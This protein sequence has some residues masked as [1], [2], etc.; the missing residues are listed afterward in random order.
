MDN[1]TR[2]DTA[3]LVVRT[4]AGIGG[5]VTAL[6]VTGCTSSSGPPVGSPVPSGGSAS[7]A[8]GSSAA[9][10]TSTEVGTTASAPGSVASSISIPPDLC[11]GTDTAQDAADAYMGSLSAGQAQQ[12]LACVYPETVPSATTL[13]LVAHA[14]GTAVYLPDP[15]AS[16][17][18][19]FVY[20]GN[21]KTIGVTVTKESDG[22]NWVTDVQVH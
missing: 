22:N 16:K 20:N 8:P 19:T 15:A 12:A 9:A 17:G 18:N 6:I 11:T 10:S 14:S 4:I 1:R 7:S 2:T 5:V 3:L 21:G 13:A